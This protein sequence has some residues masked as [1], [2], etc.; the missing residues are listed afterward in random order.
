MNVS[1]YLFGRFGQTHAIPML[2]L[3]RALFDFLTL[4]G[5]LPPTCAAQA[6]LNDYLRGGRRSKPP[7]Y[8]VEQA[9]ATLG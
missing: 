6:L 9:N 5:S 8:L 7:R 3:I 1:D 4:P 2:D